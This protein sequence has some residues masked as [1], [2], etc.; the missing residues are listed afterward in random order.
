MAVFVDLG[1]IDLSDAEPTNGR[2][3]RLEQW[4]GTPQVEAKR[5]YRA[6]DDG[7][8]RDTYRNELRRLTG[9]G[10]ELIDVDAGGRAA[11]LVQ[12][13]ADAIELS[14][15]QPAL[16][17][18]ALV[19]SNSDLV[20]LVAKLR[21][22]GRRVVILGA[23]DTD[24]SLLSNCDAFYSLDPSADEPA[25]EE[26]APTKASPHE[27]RHTDGSFS[28]PPEDTSASG[29]PTSEL[30]ASEPPTSVVPSEET[31]DATQGRPRRRRSRRRRSSPAGEETAA[32]EPPADAMAMEQSPEPPR[33]LLASPRN[34]PTRN[35]SP[36]REERASESLEGSDP[37]VWIAQGVEALADGTHDRI[38]STELQQWIRRHRPDFNE[39]ALGYDCFGDMLRAAEQPGRS[40]ITDERT[41]LDWVAL[42]EAAARD[43]VPDTDP[44]LG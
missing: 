37:L 25:R 8:R 1:G 15:E 32:A 23:S 30:P 21:D 38:S 39:H 29:A 24:E 22:L 4:L 13:T 31:P 19:S 40:V 28:E 20:P 35:S 16:N 41:G 14:L 5:A 7:G 3:G 17:T 10:T 27:E 42:G 2:L 12:L 43:D 36:A 9:R 6:V 18:I 33:R 34:R 44:T 11:M 26:A